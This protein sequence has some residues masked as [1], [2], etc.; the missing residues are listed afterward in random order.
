MYEVQV[1]FINWDNSKYG[2]HNIAIYRTYRFVK[3]SL[4]V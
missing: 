1:D 3:V 2:N 4:Y